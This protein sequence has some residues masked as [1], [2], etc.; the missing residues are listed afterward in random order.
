MVG[1]ARSP[2]MFCWGLNQTGYDSW[3]EGAFEGPGEG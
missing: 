2:V 3:R 1:I